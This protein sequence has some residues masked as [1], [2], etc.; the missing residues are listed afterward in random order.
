M[1]KRSERKRLLRIRRDLAAATRHLNRVHR[2]TDSGEPQPARVWLERVGLD[3]D[4]ARRYASQFSRGVT[5]DVTGETEI[6]LVA[7]SRHGYKTVPVKKY[8]R[9]E[10]IAQL[11]VFKPKNLEAAREF[12]RVAAIY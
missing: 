10:F 2:L 5:T 3:E 7:H 1:S 4:T 12:A 6:K 8:R 9:D 11:H